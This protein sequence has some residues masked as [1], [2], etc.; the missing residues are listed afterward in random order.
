MDVQIIHS[1]HLFLDPGELGTLSLVWS[2]RSQ[3]LLLLYLEPVLLPQSLVPLCNFNLGFPTTG[4]VFL[5]LA[6]TSVWWWYMPCRG[7]SSLDGSSCSSPLSFC[8]LRY[9][10]NNLSLGG[11][12]LM[13]SLILSVSC[14][15]V[16]LMFTSLWPPLF[17]VQP[18][19]G[20]PSV[21][22]PH[23]VYTIHTTHRYMCVCIYIYIFFI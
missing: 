10:F 19:G 6:A 17:H 13:Y 21:D 22:S 14:W 23:I 16:A 2:G 18:Q 4:M 1:L 5:I 15:I 7:L 20:G 8:S 3:L 12:F 11:I 9:S